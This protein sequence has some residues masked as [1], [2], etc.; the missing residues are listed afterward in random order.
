MPTT[1]PIPARER[2]SYMDLGPDVPPVILQRI[3]P[4]LESFL[5]TMIFGRALLLA[6]MRYSGSPIRTSTISPSVLGS[7][8]SNRR[9][10]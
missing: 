8:L 6:A 9:V 10:R 3:L 4:H 2:A 5:P 1:V 7:L